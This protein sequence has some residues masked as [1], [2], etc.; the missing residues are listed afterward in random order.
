VIKIVITG[1]T[2]YVGTRL[3]VLATR[4]GYDV[5]GASRQQPVS[6]IASWL[7][8]DLTSNEAVV[9]PVGTDVVMHLAA[10]TVATNPFDNDVDVA[11]AQRLIQSTRMAGARFFFVSSQTARADA[12]T[13][14]GRTKWRIEQAVLAA[15]GWV[16]RPGQVY[17][18][19]LRGLFGTLV[20]AVQKLPL[21][22]AFVP[23]PKVQPIHVDDL[24]EG[25]LR[26]AERGDVKPGV[27][28][29][30]APVPIS[31]SKFLAEIAKSRLRCT[32]IRVPVPVL[33]VNLFLAFIGSTWR[34]RLGL[35]R[36]RSLFGLPLMATAPDLRQLGLTLR[37]LSAGLQPSGDDRR[38]RLL[39]E[40]K[41][42]LVYVLREQ[43][44]S[45]VLRRYVR[46]IESLRE[47]RAFELH[48]VFLNYPI[49][50]S[51][52]GKTSWSD[53]VVGEEFIWRLDAATMLAEAS[54]AGAA[55][56]L[57]LGYKGGM[58]SSLLSMTNA[59]A[60]EAFWRLARVLISPILRF[61]MARVKAVS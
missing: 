17:G 12:P 52:L 2:G 51:L 9:L 30:A 49:L 18:G 60:G 39:R 31:F 59:M 56:F 37:P 22:P 7:H 34:T 36:L 45:A 25:L 42:L 47:G 4:R 41:A 3:T 61:G 5:I 16:V 23:S 26:I 50:L 11:A 13:P 8:F 38:R 55:R 24:A 6:C 21:L 46:A 54:P 35:E 27:Y 44:D 15:G 29:L 33:A 48:G 10:N 28:C 53:A 58:L 43:P 14:Y 57:G 19:E 40:G 32:R 1:A 20:M